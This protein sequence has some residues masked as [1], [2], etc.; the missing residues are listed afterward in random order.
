MKK[1]TINAVCCSVIAALLLSVTGCGK[2]NNPVPENGTNTT[3]NETAGTM[4]AN[5]ENTA[6]NDGISGNSGDGGTEPGNSEITGVTV[7]E[8]T[9]AAAAREVY[10]TDLSLD[11]D[12]YGKQLYNNLKKYDIQ[13]TE[14]YSEFKNTLIKSRDEGINAL[15]YGFIVF[16]DHYL[17]YS[18]SCASSVRLCADMILKS[19]GKD[20]DDD[21]LFNDWYTVSNISF[22]SPAYY[23]M[24]SVYEKYL[25]N[26]EK[27]EKLM[28]KGKIE[29][30]FYPEGIDVFFDMAEWSDEK[31]LE[32]RNGLADY[33]RYLYS[34]SYPEILGIERISG[35][36]CYPEQYLL[37][38]NLAIEA[39]DYEGAYRFIRAAI[40][41]APD[42]ADLYRLAAQ[43]AFFLADYDNA[44]DYTCQGLMFDA[45][46][47]ELNTWA[48]LILTVFDEY[49]DAKYFAEKALAGDICDSDRT[50]CNNILAK[51]GG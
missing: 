26:D 8:Q 32:L 33:E 51:I 44:W 23:L 20:V 30:L 37:S 3:A 6:G 31:L 24:N 48:A 46:N 19:R 38:Y 21:G 22:A 34:I 36:E 2:E 18:G 11:I 13:V 4:T 49:E 1:R 27:A 14:D 45:E 35:L 5:G 39:E 12:E 28:E 7:S 29:P 41:V 50:I 15:S 9:G 16:S 43:S 17:Y 25:G 42:Y 10:E 47:P 40:S